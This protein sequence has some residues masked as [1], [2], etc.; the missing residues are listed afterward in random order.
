MPSVDPQWQR[1]LAVRDRLRTDSAARD[2]YRALELRLAD[3]HGQ[4][5]GAYTDGKSSF[6][7]DLLAD[8]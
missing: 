7:T 4:D 1:Y 3:Q 2:A 6:L 8:E 5:R